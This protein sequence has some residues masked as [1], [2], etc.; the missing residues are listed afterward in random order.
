MSINCFSSPQCHIIPFNEARSDEFH[1]LE[2]I[3]RYGTGLKPPSYPEMRVQI[4]DSTNEFDHGS[5]YI[6]YW[7]KPEC[8][9]MTFGVKNIKERKTILNFSVNGSKA[10][11]R[12]KE[13]RMERNEIKL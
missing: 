7:K 9:I 2:L 4:L 8:N 12:L 10:L 6:A 3:A 11:F 13:W 5:Y 1:N